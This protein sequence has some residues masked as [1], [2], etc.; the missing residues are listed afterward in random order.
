MSSGVEEPAVIAPGEPRRESASEIHLEVWR[1]AWPTVITMVLQTVNGFL[2]RF[3]VGHLGPDALAAVGIS[4]QILFL[5]FSIAMAISIGTT[6]LVARNIGAGEV[7][8]AATAAN[9]SLWIAGFVSVGCVLLMMACRSPL[10][11]AMGVDAAAGGLAL[12][13]LT[14]TIL[15]IPTL[16]VML[17]LSGVFRGMGDTVTPLLVMIGVNLVHLGGA[18]VLIF[19]A[20]GAPRMGL[21][22]GAVALVASQ[23][24]GAVLY[25]IRLRR[26]GL[27]S[28]SL[29]QSRPNL[30]WF[31]RILR[32]G[33]PAAMQNMSRVLSMLVFTGLLTRTPQGTAAAAALTIGLTSESIAYLPGVAFSTAASTLTGQNL[34]A[35][36]PERAERAAWCALLQGLGIMTGMGV[37]F[38]VLAP[39]CAGLFTRDPEVHRLAV[40]Y[41]R[42][43]ALSEPFLAFGMILSGALNGA[44]DSRAPAAVTIFTMWGVRLPLS[45]ALA[46]WASLGA[47]G[48]WWG[49]AISTMIAGV[50]MFACFRHG[51]WKG[52]V[53]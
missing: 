15:G 28:I 7:E 37:L 13:Y 2:D 16:F 8:E 34:G 18:Y 52:T 48:A 3:F 26:S 36:R 33:I 44:G 23:V 11:A 20:F 25:L 24:L 53:V 41:L 31:R 22:G 43:M 21:Q 39:Q 50:L 51:R 46:V 47:I 4:G 27:G 17:I 49:M 35:R 1:L 30:A 12:Q 10:V 38:Y 19:G 5:V 45:Y 9:Q 42:T 29:R 6:A 40:A 14:L 32:I